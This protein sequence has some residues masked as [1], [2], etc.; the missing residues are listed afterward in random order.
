[1]PL[2]LILVEKQS[3]LGRAPVPQDFTAIERERLCS[4]LASCIRQTDRT[5]QMLVMV[6]GLRRDAMG[7]AD[8]LAYLQDLFEEFSLAVEE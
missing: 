2:P 3:Q 1:M 5:M 4:C 6:P 7:A 8:S